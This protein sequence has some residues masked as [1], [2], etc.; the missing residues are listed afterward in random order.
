MSKKTPGSTAAIAMAAQATTPETA[1]DVITGLPIVGNA[2]FDA[3]VDNPCNDDDM[4]GPM[5]GPVVERRRVN[6]GST[7]RI[8]AAANRIDGDLERFIAEMD[9]QFFEADAKGER[10][11]TCEFVVGLRHMRSDIAQD[12][13]AMLYPTGKPEAAE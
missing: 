8:V 10:L 12:V 7:R 4:D 11:G 6:R 9:L 13:N 1:T 2:E 3:G 5:E